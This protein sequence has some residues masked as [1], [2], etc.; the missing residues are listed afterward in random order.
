MA[1]PMVAGATALLLQKN[2]G[3]TPDQV[4]ARLMKT[5]SKNFPATSTNVDPVTG[6]SYQVTY[7]LFTV[8]AGYLDIPAALSST[9]I[10]VGSALSPRAVY[11]ESTGHTSI[12]TGPGSVWNDAVIWGTAVVWGTNVIVNSDAVVWGTAVIWG[13]QT[14]QGFAVIW[15][16]D[17]VWGSS[18]PFPDTVSIHSEK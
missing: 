3:L 10:A 17:T 11:D 14:N 8:G 13:T 1:A 12:V 16:T 15:G 2:P 5:A 4:K 18:E 6:V 9:D 7:D